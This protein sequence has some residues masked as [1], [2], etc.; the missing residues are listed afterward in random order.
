MIQA[1]PMSIETQK[2]YEFFQAFF[3]QECLQQH[4]FLL[5]FT[6]HKENDISH[7]FQEEWQDY[8][9]ILSEISKAY[10]VSIDSIQSEAFVISIAQSFN[11]SNNID[12]DDEVIYALANC[13]SI[14]FIL[15][16]LSS[17]VVVRGKHDIKCKLTKKL[18]YR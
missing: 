7:L 15:N 6:M 18:F 12:N 2:P 11:L 16:R 8:V 17:F 14:H 10:C 3:E 4:F 1:H 5:L 13:Y 9:Y